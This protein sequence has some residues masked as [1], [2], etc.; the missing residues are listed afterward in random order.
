LTFDARDS[1]LD[2]LDGIKC[3]LEAT[4][5]A[6]QRSALTIQTLAELLD[7]ALLL[8]IGRLGFEHGADQATT[9]HGHHA[10]LSMI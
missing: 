2:P 10:V 5:P 9:W 6:R 4:L 8:L 1:I 7:L 3:P